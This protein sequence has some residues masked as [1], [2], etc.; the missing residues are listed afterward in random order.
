[1][2]DPFN[3]LAEAKEEDEKQKI[4]TL[5]QKHSPKKHRSKQTALPEKYSQVAQGSMR[6]LE[7]FLPWCKGP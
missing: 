7:Q 4:N 1:M 2:L 3:L 5:V 6:F